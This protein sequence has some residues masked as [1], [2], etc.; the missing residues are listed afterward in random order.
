MKKFAS[1]TADSKSCVG[2]S[3]LFRG[4]YGIQIRNRVGERNAPEVSRR[5]AIAATGGKASHSSDSVA[6]S[7]SGCKRIP[8]RQRRHTMFPDIPDRSSGR[9]E[10][11]TREDP[12]RL[13]C[14]RTENVSRM[15]GVVAPIVDDVEDFRANNPAEH[16]QHAQI[17]GIVRV[18]P[19]CR[20]CVR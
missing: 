9:A 17:P 13:H 3:G 8:G 16:H 15:G 20:S 2:S 6:Q 12:P 4:V 7:Q 1:S 11:S 18:D 5:L 19:L 10:Q 14:R